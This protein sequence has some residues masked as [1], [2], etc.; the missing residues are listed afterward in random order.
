MSKHTLAKM[1]PRKQ[2]KK[3]SRKLRL[4][5]K[6]MFGG[7]FLAGEDC[8]I[9]LGERKNS[10]LCAFRCASKQPNN[11]NPILHRFCSECTISTVEFYKYNN[12]FHADRAI[13]QCP[14]CKADLDED[15][16]G[17]IIQGLM[18]AGLAVA[19]IT[20]LLPPIDQ[21]ANE[22]FQEELDEFHRQIVG[23]QPHDIGVFFGIPIERRTMERF[24][25]VF[26]ALFTIGFVFIALGVAAGLDF[27]RPPGQEV[28]YGEVARYL[29]AEEAE[30]MIR[31][32]QRGGGGLDPNQSY[33]FLGYSKLPYTPENRAKIK[34][35]LLSALKGV[36]QVSPKPSASKR[37][38]RATTQK[39]RMYGQRV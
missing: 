30:D 4:G 10:P 9:C 32:M 1:P 22:E 38:R 23:N 24:L 13:P 27:N 31:Q 36:K 20:A 3:R 29:R 35:T 37:S 21:A 5:R 17:Q 8:A 12:R 34:A 11:E 39:A 16:Y 6:R 26:E 15:N 19:E 28:D 14:Y 25:P 18:D 7:E 2:S 33:F